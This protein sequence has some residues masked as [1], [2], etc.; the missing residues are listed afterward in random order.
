MLN[1]GISTKLSKKEAA[2]R[3][4]RFF[5]KG[6]YGLTLT[7][8]SGSCLSFEGGGGYVT[9]TVTAEDG[10]TKIDLITQEWD[11]QVEEFAAGL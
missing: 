10:K 1:L 3:V 7:D 8:E 5:G 6:G 9:V 11:F 4:K 2:A